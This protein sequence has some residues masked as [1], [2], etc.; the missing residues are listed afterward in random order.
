VP[1]PIIDLGLM[2]YATAYQEQ[3]RHVEAVL[4]AR[5]VGAP[6][7][8][9]ILLVEHPPVITISRRAGAHDHLL[10]SPEVLVRRGVEVAETDRG[11]DITYHGPG[12]LVVYPILDLNRLNL[13]LHAYMR[14]LEQSVIEACAA[15]GVPCE[16]DPSATGVWTRA[17][18]AKVCAMGVR[19][20]RWVSMHGLA[21]NVDPDLSH[22]GLI[23]PCGLPG[24]AV[25]SLRAELGSSFPSME[26]AK[27][28][29]TRRLVRAVSA[30][31]DSADRA[32]EMVG[33]HN[34]A[35]GSPPRMH[36]EST[37]SHSR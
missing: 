9:R 28:G 24:R 10:A 25:T 22:F 33:A 11:G 15:W 36:S 37:G 29:L 6:E 21:L 7:S 20:R 35:K 26:E 1:V 5:E 31:A 4:R 18:S 13:G 34:G 16:R 12:Q 32:R 23:V 2:P 17:A 8:G 27:R 14:L 30:A 19:V 3:V